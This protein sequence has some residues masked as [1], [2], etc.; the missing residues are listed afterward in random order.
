MFEL[1]K[2]RFLRWMIRIAVKIKWRGKFDATIRVEDINIESGGKPIAARSYK[3]KDVSGPLPL[4]L[5]FHGGGW[6][7]FD[8]NTHDPLCRDLCRHTGHMIVSV[9][10]RLAP[11]HPF[12]AGVNDCLEA[13]DWVIANAARLGGDPNQIV[14]CGDSAGGNL[15][16]IV[17]LQARTRHPGKLKAQILI[18]PV[19]DHPSTQ[20][21][22][23]ASYGGKEYPLTRKGV[24]DIWRMYVQG[25]AEWRNGQT[26]H[27]LATPYRVKDI[28]GL[29]RTLVLLAEED[30]LRDEG[31]A[32]ADRMKEAGIDVKTTIF[33]K[34]KHGFVGTEPS[35]AHEQAMQEIAQW[36]SLDASK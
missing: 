15:A 26:S 18:Y 32:Y 34:Q 3:P 11:E 14:I 29:P 36:I 6:V 10:Y 25:S 27:D 20:W 28:S 30:L 9:D 5:F 16:A 2:I 19:T 35:P 8:I 23:Y 31:A 12:P 13:L 1:M 4:M 22:S 7:G 33:P 24:S 17:A 21:P